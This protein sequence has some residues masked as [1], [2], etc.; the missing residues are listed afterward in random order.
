[1]ACQVQ[2]VPGYEYPA[3]GQQTGF[4]V[5]VHFQV[6][7]GQHILTGHQADIAVGRGIAG[8]LV[9]ADPVGLQAS[10]LAGDAH[11]SAGVKFVLVLVVV[12]LIGIDLPG[13]SSVRALGDVI[14]HEMCGDAKQT[15]NAGQRAYQE[16]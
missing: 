3:F 9:Q 10:S 11:V 15:D 14:G 6:L 8:G 1:M 7:A 12:N 5:Q 13:V 4:G 2:M 16:P